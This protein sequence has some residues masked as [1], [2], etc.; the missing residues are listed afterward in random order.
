MFKKSSGENR[1]VGDLGKLLR[2]RER[3]GMTPTGD[4]NVS[5]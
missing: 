4:G 2:C 3:S 5:G 1:R